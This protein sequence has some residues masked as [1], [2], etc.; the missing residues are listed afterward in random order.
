MLVACPPAIRLPCWWTAVPEG[1]RSSDMTWLYSCP[2][3]D[4]SRPVCPCPCMSLEQA[5]WR[6][7]DAGRHVQ[8]PIQH[9]PNVAALRPLLCLCCWFPWTDGRRLRVGAPCWLSRSPGVSSR[10]DLASRLVP[11]RWTIANCNILIGPAYI[12]T[13]VAF[14]LFMLAASYKLVNRSLVYLVF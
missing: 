3:T 2:A 12:I 10:F 7:R 8:G 9:G 14:G 6:S 1:P 4:V 5:P 11:V 13:F